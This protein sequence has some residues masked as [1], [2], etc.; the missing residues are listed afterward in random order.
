MEVRGVARDPIEQRRLL[1]LV[2]RSV[3]PLGP[4][5]APVPL[6]PL[7]HRC[8]VDTATLPQLLL[9][10]EPQHSKIDFRHKY[11][12]SKAHQDLVAD[13][14]EAR[15]VVFVVPPTLARAARLPTRHIDEHLPHLGVLR[16]DFFDFRQRQP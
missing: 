12:E 4:R 11:S 8:P 16:H 3:L 1:G 14:S 10:L 15:G 9:R 2:E 13:E 5:V 7:F 6:R